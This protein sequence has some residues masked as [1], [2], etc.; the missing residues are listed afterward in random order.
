MRAILLWVLLT[1]LAA[2]VL[3]TLG[4]NGMATYTGRMREPNT[5]V[6]GNEM[7]VDQAMKS[8]LQFASDVLKGTWK[9][10]P[11]DPATEKKEVS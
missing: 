2:P 10:V 4:D 11:N 5:L 8:T 1:L 9:P 7:V 3:A 6:F